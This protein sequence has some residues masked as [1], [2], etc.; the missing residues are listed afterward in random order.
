MA[1]LLKAG[2]F[3]YLRE[4][5]AMNNL[6]PIEVFFKA[7]NPGE[8]LIF[9]SQSLMLPYLNCYS[10]GTGWKLYVSL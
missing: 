10:G 5:E 8:P 2:N 1:Y 3:N 7:S 6:L 9:R 4:F